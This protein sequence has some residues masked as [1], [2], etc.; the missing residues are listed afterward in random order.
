MEGLA[1]VGKVIGGSAF[2]LVTI[3]ATVV[4][5]AILY[6]LPALIARERRH[7]NLAPVFIVNLLFGWTLLGWAVALIWALARS[8]GAPAAAASPR[9]NRIPCPFCAAPILR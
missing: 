9:E 6:F 3:A 4:A 2:V 7:P 1:L 8:P 5:A